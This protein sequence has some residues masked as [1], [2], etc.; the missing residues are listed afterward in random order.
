[1]ATLFSKLQ[2]KGSDKILLLNAPPEF[3]PYLAELGDTVRIDRQPVGKESYDFALVF[4]TSTAAVEQQAG[5]VISCLSDDAVLWFAYP[6][7]S[8]RKYKTD[9]SRDNGWQ[10]LGA[11]G[12]EGVRI[13]AIDAD[14]S[15]F[16]AR[17][18]RHIKS[19]SRDPSR[20][21]SDEGRHRTK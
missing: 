6:K 8:S 3:Q 2:F 11:L 13:V 7:K 20:T 16:R 14:W 12:Y 15:A 9:L 1:M 18:V 10:P 4:V 5:P 21:L 19:L 17:H